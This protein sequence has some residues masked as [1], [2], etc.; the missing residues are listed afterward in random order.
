MKKIIRTVFPVL[1]LSL[2]SFKGIADVFELIGLS[3]K[4]VETSI[5]NNLTETFYEEPIDVSSM[6]DNGGNTSQNS[7][8]EEAKQFRTPKSKAFSTLTAAQK[9]LVAQE[10]CEFVKKYVNSP[11]FVAQ[12]AKRRAATK[13]TSEPYR[14][15]DV[16][17]AT[18][19]KSLKDSEQQIANAKK[20][21][22]LSAEQVKQ[23][24]D[25]LVELRKSS[26]MY[27]DPTPNKTLWNKRFPEDPAIAVKNKLQEY[28]AISSTVDFNATLNGVGKNQKFNNPDYEKKSLKWKSIYRAGKE[29]NEV[30]SAFAKEW[31]KGT[32]IDKNNLKSISSTTIIPDENNSAE[33]TTEA[34]EEEKK[35][36]K[37]GG[38][39]QK[40]KNKIKE[41]VD[42]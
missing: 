12:Y 27:D 24:D 35:P 11:E 39:L 38:L 15:S 19:K 21:G 6:E 3:Q 25:A 30:V 36:E 17:I 28:L 41:K 32:I 31:L 29:V 20:S 33:T 42:L 22:M 14:P 5:F 7:V 40:V 23:M 4:T 9:K 18:I 1:V 8:S 26:T 2:L 37:K 13:P 10:L 34:A 16:E